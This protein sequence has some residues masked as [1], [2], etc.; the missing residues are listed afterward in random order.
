[1]TAICTGFLRKR[2]SFGVLQLWSSPK[3]FSLF[4]HQIEYR[5]HETA[6]ASGIVFLD[7]T[8]TVDYGENFSSLG[9]LKADSLSFTISSKY[10]KS[11][12]HLLCSTEGEREQWI[13]RIE[14]TVREIILL[15]SK[16][17]LILFRETLSRCISPIC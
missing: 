12:E 3:L 9:N 2:T 8:T 16:G 6:A 1:M 15:Q 17:E 5:D 4:A 13:S 11:A 7:V 14:R 10:Q